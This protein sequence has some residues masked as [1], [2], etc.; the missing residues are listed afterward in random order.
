MAKIAILT[1]FMEF[2]PGYSLTGIVQ[3]QI[4]MLH[5]FGHEVILVVNE[6]YHGAAVDNC[7]LCPVLP[8]THLRDY[9]TIEDLTDEHKAIVALTAERLVEALQGVDIALTH[10]YLFTG[11][12]LPYGLACRE[13]SKS[14]PALRWF[15]WLH[16][17]PSSM[18]DWWNIR[19]Y[20]PQ[21]KLVFPNK[22]DALLV[23]EQYRGVFSDVVAIP[24][25]KDPRT[26]FEFDAD[27]CA[28]I[29]EYPAII[30]AGIVQVYPASC[31]RLA[32]KRLGEVIRIFGELKR[33]GNSVCLVVANQ[34]AT[35]RQPKQNMDGFRS[36]AWKCGL[37]PENEFIFTSQF[38][39]PRF[40]TGI[41]RRMLRELT[42]LSNLF[43]FPTR[44]ESFGLV[45]PEAC[46]S[47]AVLPVLNK[48]L[49]MMYEVSGGNGLFFDFGSNQREWNRCDDKYFADIASIIIGRLMTNEA[50]RAATFMRQT[51]NMDTIYQRYYAP[52][53]ATGE[54]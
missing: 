52:M 9:T 11:W 1:T 17:I 45:L 43:I 12:N 23:A 8:F 4:T 3:D 18:R 38:D 26:W 32:A 15:H 35:T 39:E 16:S 25:I 47:G 33:K 24:H 22:T 20:G 51:Y 46:L 30:H 34:W 6:Q 37:E 19:E 44:E 48:S 41:P 40:E 14:L 31:D 28:F 53:I 7:Q 21:H 27:T 54:I 36:T 42:Q 49:N 29:D 50:I 2:N 13:A 5:R 10:D